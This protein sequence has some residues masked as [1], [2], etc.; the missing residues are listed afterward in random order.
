MTLEEFVS[1]FEGVRKSGDGCS[2]KCSAHNDKK[3]SLHISEKDGNILV[4]FMPDARPNRSW[5]LWVSQ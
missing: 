4:M 3:P 5:Q 2:A 1:H